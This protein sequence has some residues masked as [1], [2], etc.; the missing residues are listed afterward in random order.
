MM[1]RGDVASAVLLALAAAIVFWIR[2]VPLAL[3]AVPERAAVLARAHIGARLAAERSDA[4][5]PAE[6]E[7]AVEAWTAAHPD[8][9]AREVAGETARLTAALEYEDDAGRRHPF[10]GDYDSYVWL[11]AARNYLRSGTVCDAVSGDRQCRDTLTLAPVGTA[12]RYGRSLHTAAIVA[13]HR[14][15]TWLDPSYPLT[16]SAYLVPVIVGVV[17]VV[18]AFAIG[19]R[20]AGLVGGFVAAVASAL[21][22]TLLTRSMGSDDDVWNVVLPLF[23][24]WAVIAGLQARRPLA[25]IA[26]GALG[27]VV[28]GLHAATW[29]G[30]TFGYAVVLAGLCAAGALR[31]LHWIVRQRSWRV[32]EA[33]AVRRVA[34]VVLAYY[35]AAGVCTYA[36]GAEESALR[37]PLRLVDALAHLTRHGAAPGG[38]AL[39]WPSALAMVGEL[40]VPTLGVIAMRSYGY[41][42]FFVGWLGLLLLLMPRRGW[43]VGHFAVLI[44]GTLLYR[45]LL[46]AA[47]LARSTLIA[48]LLLPLFAAVLVDVLAREPADADDTSAGMVVA[49][50]LLAALVMSYDALRFVLLL[51]A[52]LGIAMGVA[53]GRLH[54]WLDRQ[55][56][57]RFAAPGA[58]PRLLAAAAALALAILPIRIGYATSVSYLPAIDRAWAD[59]LAG[60]RSAAPPDAIINTWWDYGY[61]TEYLAERRV[62]AD[63]GTLLTHTPH[64]LARAELAASEDEAVGLL[65][66][67]NCGSDAEPYPEGAQG[68]PAKLTRHGLGERGAYDAVVRLASLDRGAADQ[69][70]AG[71]GLDAAARAD[72]LASTHCTPPAS[73]LVLSSQQVAFPGFW[74]LGEWDPARPAAACGPGESCTGF[75]TVDWAPCPAVAGGEHRCWIGRPDRHG[76]QIEAVRYTDADVRTARLVTTHP[77]HAPSE[78]APDLLLLVDG[79]AVVRLGQATPG[80][81]GT[82]LLLDPERQRALV[83]SPSAL[84]SL[85]TRLMFLDGRATSRF[86]KLDER[87]GAA[88][89]RVVTWAIDFGP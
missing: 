67:L 17:G 24:V 38:T 85:Y 80:D 83:G 19:R 71:L 10:L 45:Y 47:G 57:A 22:P 64:W 72:V 39:S 43:D 53:A 26:G 75:V 51:A 86:H 41:L 52:P 70:L 68:A 21:H 87:T 5:P 54:L 30:W 36:A 12:M 48:L 59:T 1:R 18:P 79:D 27:G 69:Y 40:T 89:Q 73:Y 14:V 63:G 3:P 60:L 25:R 29:R 32:W 20:L 8:A 82:A 88:G 28:A 15:A 56:C 4:A 76:R 7:R 62:S 55:V 34:L 33:P 42:L 31:A 6:R 74:Q 13:V 9:L 66:M 2:L 77:G 16:A 58:V 61:W 49:A 78:A 37:L 65:R 81:G 46:T 35:T 11:R 23:M 44:A 84:D 50:W